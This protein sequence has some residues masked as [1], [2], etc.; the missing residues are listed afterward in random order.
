MA[1]KQNKSTFFNTPWNER[2]PLERGVLVV[3]SVVGGVLLFTRGKKFVAWLKGLQQNI[4]INQDIAAQPNK[5][6]YQNSQYYI[7]A[8]TLYSAMQS[9]WYNPFDY[10]TDEDGVKSVMEKMRNDADVLKLVQAFG[11]KDGYTLQQWIA[12]DFSAEDKQIYV[13]GP[14]ANRGIKYRF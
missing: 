4:N 10:G 1:K 14:L 3:G 9:D 6:S 5:P 13:N 11:K 12:E 7:F 8:D 2:G